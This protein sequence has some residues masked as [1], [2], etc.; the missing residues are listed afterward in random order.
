MGKLV[1]AAPVLTLCVA[2]PVRAGERTAVGA[3][4][5]SLQYPFLVTLN[6]AM[7]AEAAKQGI[8]GTAA[9]PPSRG[10][11]TGRVQG[12]D[13]CRRFQG[14]A[15]RCEGRNPHRNRF[16]RCGRARNR[17]NGRR[18]SNADLGCL[19]A[20]RRVLQNCSARSLCRSA[21]ERAFAPKKGLYVLGP[22]FQPHS[23]QLNESLGAEN[24]FRPR[25]T[26]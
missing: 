14:R 8:D 7:A 21:I 26:A 10:G 24:V 15:G 20:R 9:L 4:L 19:I 5:L 6:N 17:S 3:V 13:R 11:P 18:L 1:I 2:G 25:G 12:T 16:S 22:G 23:R